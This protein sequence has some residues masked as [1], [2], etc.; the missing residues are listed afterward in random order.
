MSGFD[1]PVSETDRRRDEGVIVPRIEGEKKGKEAF[2]EL[3]EANKKILNAAI[4]IYLK[5]L[6]DSYHFL[7][8]SEEEK[9]EQRQLVE[10][11]K[12]FKN[13]LNHLGSKNQSDHPEFAQQLSGLWHKIGQNF[14]FIKF[15]E[16]EIILKLKKIIGEI[17]HYPKDQEHTFGYYLKEHVGQDWLPFPYMEILTNLHKEH[18]RKPHD[19]QISKWVSQIDHIIELLD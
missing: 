8:Q 3:P 13:L 4:L 9:S 17:T 7:P 10:D 16:K 6:F 18:Q 12:T 15:Q 5:S 2:A 1:K 11:L 14:N 19:S